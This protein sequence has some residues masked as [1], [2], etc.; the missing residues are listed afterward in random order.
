[1]TTDGMIKD[2]IT[3]NQVTEAD[4]DIKS[5]SLLKGNSYNIDFFADLNLNGSYDIPPLDHA[6]RLTLDNVEGDT[7]LFFSH[8]L[9][10]TDIFNLTSISDNELKQARMYPNPATDKVTI[11]TGS[12]NTSNFSLKVYDITGKII[13]VRKTDMNNKVELDVQDL[14]QGIYFVEL[15]T[16][17]YQRVMKLTIE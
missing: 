5:N 13:L 14:K 17:N 6:W 3:V 15:H 8:N 10:F 9:D 16:P 11:E 7:T 1:N 4:F 12:V 2:S